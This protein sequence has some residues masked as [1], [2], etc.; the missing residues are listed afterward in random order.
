MIFESKSAG[1]KFQ[2]TEIQSRFGEK[3]ILLSF[4]KRR[5]GPLGNGK[6]PISATLFL[7]EYVSYQALRPAFSNFAKFLS[8]SRHKF[9]RYIRNRKREALSF[10]V[11]FILLISFNQVGNIC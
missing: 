3:E 4:Q 7:P 2:V 9:N 8:F 6:E 5:F 10:K 1:E 11:S